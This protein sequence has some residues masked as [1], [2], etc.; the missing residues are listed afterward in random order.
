MG[1]KAE[2]RSGGTA[3]FVVNVQTSGVLVAKAI[4]A[5]ALVTGIIIGDVIWLLCCLGFLFFLF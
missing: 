1:P 3:I 4:F 2:E 5:K